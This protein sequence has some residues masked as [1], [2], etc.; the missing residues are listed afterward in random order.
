MSSAPILQAVRVLRDHM[1][2][3]GAEIPLNQIVIV[4]EGA[5]KHEALDALIDAVCENP[6]VTD[7]KAFREAVYARE[8]VQSTGIGGGIAIPHVRIPEISA[9]TLGVAV[10]KAGVDFGTLDN[11][12]VHILVLFATPEGSDK[13]Y[14]GLLAQVMLALRDVKLFKSL[15]TCKTPAD[16][17]ALLAGE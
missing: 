15:M 13:A 12:P 8:A 6:V 7:C 11:K 16:V 1:S 4:K 14:L 3:F 17:H 9:P 2:T 10:A 5:S